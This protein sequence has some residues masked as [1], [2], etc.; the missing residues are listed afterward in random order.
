[1]K[2]TTVIG[3]AIVAI[4]LAA[5][6]STVVPTAR[7]ATPTPTVAATPTP[8]PT[9][10]PS[11]TATPTPTPNPCA[12]GGVACDPKLVVASCDGI[13]N[14]NLTALGGS[15]SWTDT[16]PG[17]ELV[18]EP[19]HFFV[20][21]TGTSGTFGG[22]EYPPGTLSAG[23]YT[24]QFRNSN[25]DD[26]ST[27]G[28]SGSLTI[29]ACAVPANLGYTTTCAATGTTQGGSLTITFSG[30]WESTSGTHPES[31]TVDGGSAVDVTSNPF[32]SGPYTVG[33]HVFVT[34]PVGIEPV[35]E[36]GWPFAIGACPV[37]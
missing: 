19:G 15:V 12:A 23:K 31:I 10:T 36:N 25:G 30:T 11:S 20:A 13:A 14:G 27:D 33:D 4:G 37:A 16:Y 6:S 26:I 18:I 22:D 24:F 2:L 29:D 7:P 28:A 17:D 8:T 3:T 34:S 5:C 9:A 35:N 32:T 21:D 1:M